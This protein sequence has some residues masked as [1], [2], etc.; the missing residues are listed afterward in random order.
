[1]KDFLSHPL[2]KSTYTLGAW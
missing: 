1:M 2:L